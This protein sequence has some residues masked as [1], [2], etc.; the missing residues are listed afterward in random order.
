MMIRPSIIMA[1]C[2]LHLVDLLQMQQE[3]IQQWA[4]LS[5]CSNLLDPYLSIPYTPQFLIKIH[6]KLSLTILI[7]VLR[8]LKRCQLITGM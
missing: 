7:R 2:K 8:S 5:S 3:G 4:V 6:L 1:I